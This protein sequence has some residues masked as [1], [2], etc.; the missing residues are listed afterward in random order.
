LKA[1][2]RLDVDLHPTLAWTVLRQ[3]L[4]GEF[5]LAAFAAL[6]EVEIRVRALSGLGDEVIGVAL[7]AAAFSPKVPGPL[8]D[9]TAE[10]GEHEA[11]MALFRGVLGTFKNPSSHRSLN[12]DDPVLA[13][14]VV[15]LAGLLMRLLDR[16]EA[17][18][19]FQLVS[20]LA[21]HVSLRSR[22]TATSACPRPR[23][24]PGVGKNIAV[25]GGDLISEAVTLGDQASVDRTTPATGATTDFADERVLGDGRRLLRESVLVKLL[26]GAQKS[27]PTGMIGAVRKSIWFSVRAG[28][29][30]PDSLAVQLTG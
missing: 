22:P 14:E 8:A 3:F 20:R 1:G 24:A 11:M 30:K 16:A 2:Q 23:S 6:R 18:R 13:A 17:R 25:L 4:L 27:L 9:S 10:A 15:L 19:T 28:R 21:P 26:T 29:L 5:E 12:Y 7:M